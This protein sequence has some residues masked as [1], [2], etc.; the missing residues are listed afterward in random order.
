M[1][2]GTPTTINIVT[3]SG[4]IKATLPAYWFNG[5]KVCIPTRDEDDTQFRAAVTQY[6]S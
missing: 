2:N 1:T 4:K 3:R 5:R 6:H